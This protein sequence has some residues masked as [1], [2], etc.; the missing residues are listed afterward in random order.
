ML[1]LKIGQ[2]SLQ[3]SAVLCLQKWQQNQANATIFRGP[4]D[5]SKW[6]LIFCRLKPR[7]VMCQFMYFSVKTKKK[8]NKF[9]NMFHK[10]W[11]QAKKTKTKQIQGFAT[12]MLAEHATCYGLLANVEQ[13]KW[14]WICCVMIS[15]DR[16]TDSPLD[17]TDFTLSWSAECYFFHLYK[18]RTFLESF[19]SI[20][21]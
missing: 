3:D 2:S 17:Y 19:C 6:L 8:H 4:W 20:W 15:S 7:C 21:H 18:W 13:Y 16:S 11:R 5:Y 12:S 1:I 14:N 9:S 10:I